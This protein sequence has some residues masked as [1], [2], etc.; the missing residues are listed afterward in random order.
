[1]SRLALKLAIAL[2]PPSRRAWGEAMRGEYE[3]LRE[4]QSAF[5]LG[6]LGSSLKENVATGEGWARIGFG[7]VLLFSF[8]LAG[9]WTY[10]TFSALFEISSQ[11]SLKFF[12]TLA[13][14]G[15][16][17]YPIVLG[18]AAQK[19]LKAPLD[20]F[21]L[22]EIGYRMTFRCLLIAGGMQA[23]LSV[24]SLVS[25]MVAKARHE[26][27]ET[28]LSVGLVS[29]IFLLS[30]AWFARH[31]ARMTRNA[32]AVA[33][34]LCAAFYGLIQVLMPSLTDNSGHDWG[35]TT[36]VIGFLM[37]LTMIASALFVWMQ[38]PARGVA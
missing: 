23:L 35:L 33:L 13:T 16:V 8:W 6:C 22:A 18:L 5:A 24:I 9:F 14:I 26:Q 38:R 27:L 4:N 31:N 12:W 37:L 2:L 30:V 3:H 34:L 28:S 19:A 20:R 1:M 29:A 21:Q 11:F 17:C 25:I 10:W 32:A 7:L 15:F 36:I